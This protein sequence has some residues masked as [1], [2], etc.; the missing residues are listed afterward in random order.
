[1]PRGVRS[2]RSLSVIFVCESHR[3]FGVERVALKLHQINFG[4]LRRRN[5]T[6]DTMALGLITVS[7]CNM[8]NCPSC[9]LI[10][11][12]FP[13]RRG[14]RSVTMPSAVTPKDMDDWIAKVR[15]CEHLTENEL[16][17]L[18]EKVSF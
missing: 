1:M 9:L 18:C 7:C 17:S 14:Q 12:T 11:I 3:G 13:C 15:R 2:T 4:L 6:Y 10:L 8:L 16:K 5:P